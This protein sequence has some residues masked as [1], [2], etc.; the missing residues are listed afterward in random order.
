MKFS[1]MMGPDEETAEQD[2]GVS[3][4]AGAPALPPLAH[5]APALPE[6][7]VRFGGTRS[8]LDEAVAGLTQVSEPA[9]AAEPSRAFGPPPGVPPLPA[10]PLTEVADAPDEAEAVVEVPEIAEAPDADA[11]AAVTTPEAGAVVE[12][13]E[14]A[15]APTGGTVAV[16]PE[17]SD[18]PLGGR[19]ALEPAAEIL[20]DRAAPPVAEPIEP[21][22]PPTASAFATI[23]A[24]AVPAVD[25]PEVETPVLDEPVL[26]ATGEPDDDHEPA[27]HDVMAELGPRTQTFDE[28]TASPAQLDTTSW[29]EGLGSI[30]DDLLP[31]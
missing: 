11:V 8:A 5:T 15:E 26:D 29:L 3:T 28:L 6:T 31:R 7:P 1:D 12:A 2:A 23:A 18:P 30:D 19:V 24:A 21:S 17:V 4:D 25:E 20:T 22:R 13:P 14:I 16:E 10:P 9:P 27:L